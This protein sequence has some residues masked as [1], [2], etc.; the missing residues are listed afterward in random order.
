MSSVGAPARNLILAGVSQAAAM[1]LTGHKTDSIFRRYAI[2]DAEVQLDA[3]A[4]LAAFHDAQKNAPHVPKV[5]TAS[6]KT[7]ARYGTRQSPVRRVG[8][9]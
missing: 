1:S 2:T 4:K 6:P 3:V 7:G 5:A 8:N 9:A